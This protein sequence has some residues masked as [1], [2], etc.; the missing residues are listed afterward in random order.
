MPAPT[1]A[2]L[3]SCFWAVEHWTTIQANRQIR[4]DENLCLN[5]LDLKTLVEVNQAI[6]A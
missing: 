3:G 1:I 5:I 2:I 4:A 6:F